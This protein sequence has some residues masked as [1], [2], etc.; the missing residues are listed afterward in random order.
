MKAKS[1]MKSRIVVFLATLGLAAVVILSV[2][3]ETYEPNFSS[4]EVFVD[5]NF[6]EII[7]S[8]EGVELFARNERGEAG[9]HRLIRFDEMRFNGNLLKFNRY[10]N[11]KESK[12]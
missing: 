5:H 6:G 10:C 2:S 3:S 7:V 4:S 11:V 8:E 9:L 12:Q 1:Q